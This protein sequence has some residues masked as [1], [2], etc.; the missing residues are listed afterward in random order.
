LINDNVEL[1]TCEYQ[2]MTKLTIDGRNFLTT[3]DLMCIKN[4]RTKEDVAGLYG[5]KN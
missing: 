3:N 2:G 1:I 5:E 4:D